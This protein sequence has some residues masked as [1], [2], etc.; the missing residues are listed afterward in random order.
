[1]TK[2][3]EIRSKR[4]EKFN[5]SINAEAQK[6]FDWILDL[7]DAD[8]ERDYFG[9][10]EVFLWYGQ[11]KIQTNHEDVEYDLTE[12]L[13]QYDRVK[14]FNSLTKLIDKEEGFKADLNLD[15]NLWGEKAIILSVVM[16]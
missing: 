9:S 10:C 5:I 3:Q 2:A 6:I 11:S 14:L 16:E 15:G 1:M 7:M 4:L 12:V 8:T 13:L